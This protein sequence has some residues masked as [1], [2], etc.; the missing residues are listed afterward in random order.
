MQEASEFALFT[1]EFRESRKQMRI[2]RRWLSTV[3]CL[4]IIL[5]ILFLGIVLFFVGRFHIEKALNNVLKGP[6]KN[7][8][9][10]NTL[11]ERTRH[12]TFKLAVGTSECICHSLGLTLGCSSRIGQCAC[13][14]AVRGFRGLLHTTKG[15]AKLCGAFGQRCRVAFCR[16]CARLLRAIKEDH[17]FM[18]EP[19]DAALSM[20][21]LSETQDAKSPHVRCPWRKESTDSTPWW[22]RWQRSTSS[23][24][25]VQQPPKDSV[26]RF[27]VGWLRN[28][29]A[30]A[31]VSNW[32]RCPRKTSSPHDASARSLIAH[33][34]RAVPGKAS[35][36]TRWQRSASNDVVVTE[37]RRSF[38]MSAELQR[39]AAEVRSIWRWPWKRDAQRRSG[40]SDARKKSG[41]LGE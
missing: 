7:V 19:L 29:L 22:P 20:L 6:R 33:L 35:K 18:D 16:Q 36:Q 41:M 5:F 21:S 3:M 39:N 9:S 23:L 15:A 4:G 2:D 26:V 11:L 14:H 37:G 10:F 28:R 25:G 34:K 32:P 12:G 17:V 24:L 1:E 38:L 27:F 30:P 31:A 13:V 40:T 8:K